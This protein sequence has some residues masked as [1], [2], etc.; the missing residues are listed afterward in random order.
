MT[1]WS[2][3][4][5]C[6]LTSWECST[7]YFKISA[8]VGWFKM[9]FNYKIILFNRCFLHRLPRAT[10][11]HQ[12]PQQIGKWWMK[13]G[14]STHSDIIIPWWNSATWVS[15][16]SLRGCFDN[17][18]RIAFESQ[19]SLP[20]N[21]SHSENN[22]DSIKV[23]VM[24]LILQICWMMFLKEVRAHC[25]CASLQRTQIHRPCHASSGCA[26]Y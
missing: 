8:C 5:S 2:C 25:Y 21:L 26:K 10:S 7:L 18:S 23:V 12:I 24:M 11:C 19:L 22:L 17:M 4:R 6:S 9:I 3:I 14:V 20:Q 1:L 16:K 15:I 13:K